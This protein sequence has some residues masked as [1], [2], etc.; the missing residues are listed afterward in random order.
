MSNLLPCPSCRRHVR[1]SDSKC[2]FCGE[3][4]MRALGAIASTEPRQRTSRGGIFLFGAVSSALA[5]AGCG[6]STTEPAPVVTT[7][8]SADGKTDGTTSD[9]PGGDAIDTGGIGPAYGAP[10]DS[11]TADS[12]TSS[13][14]G[15]GSVK[16]TGGGGALYG[17]APFH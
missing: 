12:G 3:V 16:D 14:A 17:A 5:V 15:D 7:D 1:G 11:G 6:S 4:I 8:S 9:S 10:I 2:P 13:D